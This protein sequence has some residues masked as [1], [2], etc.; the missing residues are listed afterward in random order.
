MRRWYVFIVIYLLIWSFYKCIVLFI[1]TPKDDGV[2]ELNMFQTSVADTILSFP[3]FKFSSNYYGN[4]EKQ[5]DKKNLYDCS[6]V[7]S[8]IIKMD[9]KLLKSYFE[10]TP[11][12][13]KDKESLLPK[14]VL[15]FFKFSF[16]FSFVAMYI[17]GVAIRLSKERYKFREKIFNRIVFYSILTMGAFV[18][19][20]SYF[21]IEDLQ[22]EFT[23]RSID[24]IL[25]RTNIENIET[26]VVNTSLEL[27]SQ[28]LY[29]SI[30]NKDK[31]VIITPYDTSKNKQKILVSYNKENKKIEWVKEEV[32]SDGTSEVIKT[33]EE[34]AY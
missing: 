33:W 7:V 25:I 27:K 26:V 29:L 1:Y 9:K 32:K 6:M 2:I 23:K 16:S 10:V 28:K 17:L 20:A 11:V 4:C 24:E 5:T 19:T 22:N 30:T 3:T 15:L 21:M 13:S 31:T 8:R 18:I 12:K 34:K 14:Y